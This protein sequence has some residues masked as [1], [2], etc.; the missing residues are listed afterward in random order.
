MRCWCGYLSGA[1]CRLFVYGPADATTIPNSHNLLPHLNPHHRRRTD[2]S[3]LF[4][5]WHSL[6]TNHE[7]ISDWIFNS[8]DETASKRYVVA[9]YA[10]DISD[11]VTVLLYTVNK[12][13]STSSRWR[14]KPAGIGHTN[15]NNVT[16]TLC[17]TSRP[18]SIHT[19]FPQPV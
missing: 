18:P 5:R 15:R 19:L 10:T 13:I 12:L 4:A 3:I 2:Y 9:Y 17:I 16:A 7:H 1:R 11:I 8:R 14:R 6:L